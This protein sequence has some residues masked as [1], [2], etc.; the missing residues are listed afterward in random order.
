MQTIF[1]FKIIFGSHIKKI[2]TK[3][4]RTIRLLRKLQQ[5]VP[6]PSLIVIY[7]AFIRPNLYNGDIILDEAFNNFFHQRLESIQYNA[8][9][10]RISKDNLY[11]ELSFKPLQS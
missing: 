6:S 11:Q 3:V 5:V 2:L 9:V 1:R 8:V 7:T 4:I 10:T